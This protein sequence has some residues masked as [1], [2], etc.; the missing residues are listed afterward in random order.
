MSFQP[1][2]DNRG[3]V[4]LYSKDAQGPNTPEEGFWELS[5]TLQSG[6]YVVDPFVCKNNIWNLSVDTTLTVSGGPAPPPLTIL[7]GMYELYQI[8]DGLNDY[9]TAN[10]LGMTV[11][12][13][14]PTQTYVYTCTQDM[15]LTFS[16]AN[17]TLFGFTTRAFTNPEVYRTPQCSTI[18]TD[19]L[20]F[21]F[22]GDNLG[23]SSGTSYGQLMLTPVGSYSSTMIGHGGEVRFESDMNTIQYKI[24]G[25]NGPVK[26]NAD[27]AITLYPKR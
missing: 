20:L 27:F 10:T 19:Y 2:A 21:D 25:S 26:L 22:V 3:L 13:D 14:F 23:S 16:P 18:A 5:N 24:T 15:T 4:N 11:S 6:T 17:E 12:I 1:E 8:R 9:F 7:A